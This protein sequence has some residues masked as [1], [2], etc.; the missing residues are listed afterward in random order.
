MRVV[1][2]ALGTQRAV[3]CFVSLQVQRV[4]VFRVCFVFVTAGDPNVLSTLEGPQ[5]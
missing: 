1:G 5:N 2:R 3:R 4:F